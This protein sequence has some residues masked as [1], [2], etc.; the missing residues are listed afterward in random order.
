MLRMVSDDGARAEMRG[1]LDEIVLDGRHVV[2]RLRLRDGATEGADE[3]SAMAERV[4]H[5]MTA[6]F[7]A[8]EIRPIADEH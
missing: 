5:R 7:L 1:A 6:E 2:L 8:V 3:V 4:A